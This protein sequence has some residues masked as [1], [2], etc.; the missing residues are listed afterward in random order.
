MLWT[1]ATS[2]IFAKSEKIAPADFDAR[3]MTAYLESLGTM[4]ISSQ[5]RKLSSLRGLIREL[6]DQHVIGRIRHRR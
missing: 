2:W 6:V 3:A 4:A 1:C 5:R